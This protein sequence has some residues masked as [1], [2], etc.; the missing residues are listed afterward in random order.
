MARVRDR[1]FAGFGAAL[2]LITASGLTIFVIFAGSNNSEDTAQPAQTCV[3]NNSE[4]P[5]PVPQVYKPTEPVSSLQKDDLTVGD[6]ATA[7]D[8]DCLVVKYYGTLAKDGTKFDE[9]FTSNLGF[10]FTLGTGQVIPGWDQGLV[11]MKVGGT[12]RLV[13]PAALGY[14]NQ[15]SGSIPANSDLVFVVKLL[16]IQN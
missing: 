8:G 12:R 3:E 11:G 6:G 5:L 1:I 15:A 4:T 13:I 14:G 9:N 2:F 16:R 10:A 7:K